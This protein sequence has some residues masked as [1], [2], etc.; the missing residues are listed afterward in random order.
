M[1]HHKFKV[2]LISLLLLFFIEVKLE[3]VIAQS[4]PTINSIT[5]NYPSSPVPK[6]DKFEITFDI[7]NSQAQNFQFPYVSQTEADQH[8]DQQV[9]PQSYL[10]E[11]VDQGISVDG[12]FLP[13]GQSDWNNAYTTPGFYYQEFLD[14][15]KNNK[16]WYYPT[17]NYHWKVRFSPNQEGRWQYKLR[18][19]DKGGIAESQ[20]FT[21]DVSPS[22]NHGFIKVS[23]DD[24]RY[25]E[26][27]DGTY[28]PATGY[29]LGMGQLQSDTNLQELQDN[30]IQFVR[31]WLAPFNINSTAWT[32]WEMMPGHYGGYLPRVPSVPYEEVPGS[33]QPRQMKFIVSEDSTWFEPCAFLGHTQ[34]SPAVKSN[35]T[36]YIRAK[37]KT[38]NVTGPRDPVYPNYGFVIKIGGWDGDCQD[39]N[40]P[41]VPS[42]SL[43]YPA[44]NYGT[45]TNWNYVQGEWNSGTNNF[46]PNFY[47]VLENASGGRAYIESI[48]MREKTGGTVDNPVLT[49]QNIVEKN[50]ADE[51]TYFTQTPSYK[52]DKIVEK[53][54]NYDMY[55]RPVLLE[56]GEDLGRLTDAYG[57][58]ISAGTSSSEDNFYG[59]TKRCTNCREYTAQRWLQDAWFRYVQARWGYSPNIHSWEL[60]NE[61]DPDHWGHYAQTDEMGKTF[62][63]RVFGKTIGFN[64]AQDC[65]YD[66]PN[67]HMVSTSF[68]HSF[69]AGAFW[70][71]TIYPNVDYA[72]VHAYIS[73]SNGLNYSS[74]CSKAEMSNDAAAY[75]ECHSRQYYGRSIGKPIIRG[76][77]GMDAAGNQSSTILNIQRDTDGIWLHNYIWA[78]LSDGGLIEQYWWVG[79]HID[80]SITTYITGTAGNQPPAP[81]PVCD[82]PVFE[83]ANNRWRFKCYFDNRDEYANYYNFVKDI[84]LNKG[85]YVDAAP[86]VGNPNLRVWGQKNTIAGNAHVWIQN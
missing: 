28:F 55:V 82:T 27:D 24:S 69:P 53:L 73:T 15:V 25:F 83:T 65:T 72:D 32:A 49:G 39:P 80:Y 19:T 85:G 68:W 31:S 20:V 78:G 61:G 54:K 5:T 21:F 79:E 71:N 63:C 81:Y 51:L 1:N 16:P 36:Y 38:M 40:K 7:A 26:F 76:E 64:D 18:V 2:I 75:H 8:T 42:F 23:P 77:A 4:G 86:A 17:E 56:K 47:M 74:P 35:T 41:G 3:Y 9:P 62:N 58:I 46:L 48:E 22:T 37:Y 45:D 13:P 29:N 57:K 30:K 10:Q 33:G 14:Q 66:H 52:M 12:L 50:S 84:L 70:K 60:L 34:P 11:F 67:A 59:A 6:Y 43:T 44:T